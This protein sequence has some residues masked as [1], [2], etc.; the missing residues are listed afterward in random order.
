[1]LLDRDPKKFRLPEMCGTTS[2]LAGEGAGGEGGVR[3]NPSAN[4][5]YAPS[6]ILPHH[7]LRNHEDHLSATGDTVPGYAL[8]LV[9]VLG[10]D[11]SDLL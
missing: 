4:E 3:A 7:S 2:P 1:M 8:W 11:L 5:T 6:T 9:S 10:T